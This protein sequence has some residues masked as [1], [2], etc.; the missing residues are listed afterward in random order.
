MMKAGTFYHG[1]HGGHRDFREKNRMARM[2]RSLNVAISRELIA[3]VF[4]LRDLCDLCG[5]DIIGLAGVERWQRT[6]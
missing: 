6:Y 4:V 2:F 3:T 1:E 5:K